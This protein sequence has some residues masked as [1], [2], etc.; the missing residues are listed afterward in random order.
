MVM[1]LLGLEV[2]LIGEP[3]VV[4][5]DV[6]PQA[7]RLEQA[8]HASVPFLAAYQS[9][10][11]RVAD[12]ALRLRV[13]RSL[14]VTEVS[15]N[16]M[17][18]LAGKPAVNAY[19]GQR[20]QQVGDS[21]ETQKGARAVLTLD[22]QAGTIELAPNTLLR[23]QK[24]TVGTKGGYQTQLFLERGQAKIKV[25]KFEHP[26]ASLDIQ[27]PAGVSGV[28]G[29]EFGMAVQPNG[30][31]GIG[32]Q[33]GKV[34]VTGQA[35]SLELSAGYQTLLRLGRSPETAQA[36]RNQPQLKLR[37]LTQTQGGK[38]HFSGQIDPINLLLVNQVA[39]PIDDQGRFDLYLPLSPQAL[40]SPITATVITPLGQQQRYELAI[41]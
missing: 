2:G 20:L 21:I 16:V 4:P 29:T 22:T 40:R 26:D 25:K 10:D 17:V 13:V 23:I 38:I 8:R 3:K 1:T 33:E 5:S 34:L 36:L 7:G 9:S 14:D 37:W 28:R 41:P 18:S 19:R 39:H 11:L 27:T 24:M 6:R 30:D 35:Q 15:G 31:T 12:T 32:T